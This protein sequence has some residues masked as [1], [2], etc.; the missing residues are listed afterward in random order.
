MDAGICGVSV[1]DEVSWEYRTNDR[2]HSGAGRVIGF[3]AN[4]AVLVSDGRGV[5]AMEPRHIGASA[6]ETPRSRRQL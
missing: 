3:T 4:G 6:T 1:G 2:A 5:L